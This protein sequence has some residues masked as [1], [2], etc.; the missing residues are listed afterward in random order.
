[1]INRW[2]V[3]LFLAFLVGG[4][5][6]ETNIVDPQA[7]NSIQESAKSKVL[8]SIGRPTSHNSRFIKE[9]WIEKAW[10]NSIKNGKHYKEIFNSNQIVL[11]INENP[12]YKIEDYALIWKMYDS[13]GDV[14]GSG[15]GALIL[16]DIGISDSINLTLFNISDSTRTEIGSFKFIKINN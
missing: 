1:M 2:F 6:L 7:S 9:I 10:K 4:C 15:N 5:D 12:Q 3:M 8:V 16:D 14:F 13:K 11:S